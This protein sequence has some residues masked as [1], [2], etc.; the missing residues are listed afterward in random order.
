M[1]DHNIRQIVSQISKTMILLKKEII[2][3]KKDKKNLIN[4]TDRLFTYEK[5]E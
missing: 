1:K 5:Y 3:L 2:S 4:V